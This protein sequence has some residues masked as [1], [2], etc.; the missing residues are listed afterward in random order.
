MNTKTPE[1][2]KNINRVEMGHSTYEMV[3]AKL[4]RKL[5]VERDQ[6][7]EDL[8]SMTE[9]TPLHLREALESQV[10]M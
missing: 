7:L 2:D 9:K 4:A 6:A 8:K 5:E 3:S 10:F 1:T